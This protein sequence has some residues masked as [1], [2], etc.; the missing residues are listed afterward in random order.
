LDNSSKQLNFARELNK[1][2]EFIEGDVNKLPFKGK[3]F[4]YITSVEVIEHVDK[5]N[6]GL[7][8][9]EIKRVLKDDGRIVITTPNYRS[10]W[11]AIEFVWS[12]INPIDYSSEHINRQTFKM[13]E[14]LL[15]EHGFKIVD[16]YSFF[17]L[18]P[19]LS[20]ISGRLAEKMHNLE[21]KLFPKLGSIILV[22]AVKDG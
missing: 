5:H 11:P 14:R 8:L 16:R 12:K 2:A 3:S 6:A 1:N 18:S 9:D 4:D 21:I 17:I 19:F 15:K 22:E 13:L 10:L 7:M 20:F